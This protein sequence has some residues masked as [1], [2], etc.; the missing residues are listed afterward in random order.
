MCSFNE[1]NAHSKIE[2][3]EAI[4]FLRTLIPNEKLLSIGDKSEDL[5]NLKVSVLRKQIRKYKQFVTGTWYDILN[6]M[7]SRTHYVTLKS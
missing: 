5:S 1:V 2:I 4:Q 6:P 3:I 7:S